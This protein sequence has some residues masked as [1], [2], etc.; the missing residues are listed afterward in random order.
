VRTVWLTINVGGERRIVRKLHSIKRDGFFGGGND[1]IEC[2]RKGVCTFVGVVLKR[3]SN[4]PSNSSFNPVAEIVF[5]GQV[6]TASRVEI[7]MK[8]FLA[9]EINAGQNIPH[10]RHMEDSLDVNDLLNMINLVWGPCT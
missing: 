5:L 8:K 1:M 6:K 3:G 10:V 7:K 9:S 4:E 2:K